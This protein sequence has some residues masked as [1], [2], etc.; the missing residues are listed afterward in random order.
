[1]NCDNTSMFDSD[2]EALFS[3][4]RRFFTGNGVDKDEAKGRQMISE[5]A[6]MGHSMAIQFL[7]SLSSKH[8]EESKPALKPVCASCTTSP[9]LQYGGAI[10]GG[11][12]CTD[13]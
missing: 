6:A 10:L 1:M 13:A 3:V 7:A 8:E 2:A 5:A 11:M 12:D 9:P 4:G